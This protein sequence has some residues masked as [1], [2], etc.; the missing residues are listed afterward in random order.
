MQSP[1]TFAFIIA[2]HMLL[3][4]ASISA[5]T[6]P[7]SSPN[8]AGFNREPRTN[9]LPQG[10][11]AVDFLPNRLGAGD[12]LIVEVGNDSRPRLASGDGYYVHRSSTADCSVQFE[13]GLPDFTFQGNEVEGFGGTTVAADPA[14][15][16]FFTAD[17]RLGQTGGVGLFRA[18]V[19]TLLDTK[20]CPNGTHSAAKSTSCWTV[21]PPVLLFPVPG[22]FSGGFFSIAV[23]ERP[24]SAGTGAGDVYVVTAIADN[25]QNNVSLVACTNMLNCGPAIVISAGEDAEGSSYVRVRPDGVITVNYVGVNDTSFSSTIKF[26]TCTPAGAPNPPVCTAPTVVQTLTGAAP[27][28]LDS[29]LQ[30]FLIPKHAIRA[31]AGGKF[32]NFLVYDNCQNSFAPPDSNAECLN[33]EVLLTSSTDNGKTWSTPI[34]VDTAAGNHLAS[35]ITTDPVTGFTQIAYYSSEGDPFQHQVRVFRNQINPGSTAP[36]TPQMVTQTLDPLDG[37]ETTLIPNISF[38]GAAARGTS[39]GVTSRLYVSFTSSTVAGTYE[40]FSAPDLNN[41]ITQV[42]F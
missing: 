1:R 34:S 42:S 12:D 3:L 16:A 31:E 22:A 10:S 19:S 15:D 27:N 13:G 18:S 28:P 36:G 38:L 6:V 23:D 20:A 17:A 7:C 21:T 33:A 5:A 35:N 26:V 14:R 40:G 32:T 11:G 41:S 39:P 8:G 9:A 37:T 2:A 29:N 4:T 24:T 30:P 25:T